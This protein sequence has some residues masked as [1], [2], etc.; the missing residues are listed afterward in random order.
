MSGAERLDI[1]LIGL[2]HPFRGGIAHYTTRL[3]RALAEKHN[4]QFYALSRQYPKLLFPGKTQIDESEAAWVAPHDAC[5]DSINPVTWITTAKSIARQKPQLAIFSW[6][7]PFFAPS[8]GS[9][10]HLARILADVP[11]CFLCHNALPHESSVVDKLLSRYAFAAGSIFVAHSKQDRD[12]LKR[13]RPNAIVHQNPHPTYDMFADS[14]RLTKEEAK[15]KLDLEGK[16]VLLFFGFIREYKGLDVLLEAVE[17]LP[18]K[19]NYHLLVVGEFYEDRA[20][21]QAS[22][23]RLTASGRLTLVDRY[24]ANEEVPLYFS[25]A[26][27]LMVPYL[28]ATQSGVIQIGYA[29]ETPV[30]ATQVGGIPEVVRDGETGYLIEPGQPE[31]MRSAIMHHFAE[32]DPQKIATAIEQENYKYSWERMVETIERV[33]SELRQ[34]R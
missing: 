6:W 8:F 31:P 19:D 30:V 12:N 3:Y 34:S 7:H 14:D 18:E 24:V 4:V 26:D 1:A 5:I 25:A 22:L 32:G 23:D 28:T 13:L 11:S 16:R 10:A 21:Y 27:L 29:F 33:H 9:I 15:R 2:T 17:S 20:K